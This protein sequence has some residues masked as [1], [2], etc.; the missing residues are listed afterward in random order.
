MSGTKTVHVDW[1][2]DFCVK[3]RNTFSFAAKFKKNPCSVESTMII[4]HSSATEKHIF[5]H[6]CSDEHFWM[7][8]HKIEQH[9][10]SYRIYIYICVVCYQIVFK[11]PVTTSAAF[12][13]TC[14]GCFV[15]GNL[16]FLYLHNTLILFH[17]SLQQ[18]SSQFLFKA[19]STGGPIEHYFRRK[20]L[21]LELFF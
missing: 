8:I 6:F 2:T 18:M 20:F 15:Y 11:I 7:Y 13:P 3:K 4:A 14:T 21:M 16:I 10:K 9:H 19:D 5:L 1:R 17:I 12:P